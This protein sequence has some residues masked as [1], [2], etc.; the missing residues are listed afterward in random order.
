[1]SVDGSRYTGR[2]S[3]CILLNIPDGHAKEMPTAGS[4]HKTSAVKDVL[5][6]SS[7]KTLSAK[8]VCLFISLLVPIVIFHLHFDC[9][10]LFVLEL[11]LTAAVNPV[12]G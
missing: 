10:V 12:I 11:C 2:D 6:V 1:V 7:N 3:P 4:K 8:E 5:P 9:I